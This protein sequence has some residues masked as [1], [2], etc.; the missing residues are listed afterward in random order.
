MIGDNIKRLR[1]Q[2]GWTQEQLAEKM[3]YTSKSTINKIE[4]NINDVRQKKIKQFA[5]VFNCD[6]AELLT[7]NPGMAVSEPGQVLIAFPPEN[8][9]DL[10]EES[11]E[12]AHL[13][14]DAD[15]ED[16]DIVMG[17]LRKKQSKS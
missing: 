3:G 1:E 7:E 10:D 12:F 9:D 4:K 15:K 17:F 11:I 13:F 16:R 14:Q 2:R 6:P 5:D 8:E